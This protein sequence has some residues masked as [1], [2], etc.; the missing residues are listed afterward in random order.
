VIITDTTAP[1]LLTCASNQ[2]LSAG[3]NCRA[4]LP[5]LAPLVN[6]TDNCSVTV[7]QSPPAG[8]SLGLGNSVVTLTAFDPAGNSVSC[9]ATVTVRDTTAPTANCP[10]DQYAFTT[11]ATGADVTFAGTATDNCDGNVQ[12]V[13]V[14]ASGTFF[15]VG[16]NLVQCRAT[17]A[18]GNASA[19]S[20]RVLVT[21]IIEGNRPPVAMD[22][23]AGV[24]EGRAARI[25]L[26][27]LLAND[28]DPDGDSLQVITV[29]PTSARGASVRLTSSNVTYQALLGVTGTDV[30][31]YTV[32]DGQGGTATAAVVMLLRG[33]NEPSQNLVGGLVLTPHGVLVRFAG[34]P[35]RT[36][37][38]QRTPD[39]QTPWTT[40]GYSTVPT[41]GIGEFE[42][43]APP[44]GQAFY[45]AI[46]P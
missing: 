29:S 1:T 25:P 37:V 31:S 22:N 15:L 23:A 40:L 11:N 35:G 36:Y 26:A 45:R 9:T 43:T 16:E 6:A 18:Q 30:F 24:T 3:A 10:P 20:F 2:T 28:S 42:D 7:T 14:P 32:T 44:P 4:T 8:V 27:K 38:I 34:I 19:C 33:V 12:L 17:D 41:D 21:L 5:D 46:A 13:C 39:L